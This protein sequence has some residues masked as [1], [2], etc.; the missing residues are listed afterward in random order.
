MADGPPRN[1]LVSAAREALKPIR[2]LHRPVHAIFSWSGGL[3]LRDPC[4]DCGGKA[5]VHPCGCWGDTDVTFHCLT[6]RTGTKG[7]LTE[8][9]CGTAK[10]VYSS[11]ELD[12]GV[13]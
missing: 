9:P 10:L 11:E 6:C 8:W 2:E 4:P 5:G 1:A 13:L 7:R 3:E 12:R